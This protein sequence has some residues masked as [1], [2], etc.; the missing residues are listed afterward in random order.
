MLG[1]AGIA[2]VDASAALFAAVSY[3]G[4]NRGK[5][6]IGGGDSQHPRA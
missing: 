3:Q 5:L 4:A 1:R 2:I 6:Q